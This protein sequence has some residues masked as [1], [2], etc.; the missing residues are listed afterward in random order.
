MVDVRNLV[1]QVAEAV[2]R[3]SEPLT[4]AAA[5][6]AEVGVSMAAQGRQVSVAVTDAVLAALR[7]LPDRLRE[8]EV[9][10]AKHNLEDV[11]DQLGKIAVRLRR[12]SGQLGEASS[13]LGEPALRNSGQLVVNGFVAAASGAR[14]LRPNEQGAVRWLPRAIARPYVDGI[15]TV[16]LG[17]STAGDLARACVNA[18]PGMGA[19]LG[20]IADDLGRAS[21]L[22]EATSK[23]IRD[24]AELVPI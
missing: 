12:L 17:L 18:L 6:T 5:D 23:T 24:L 10:R 16:Y 4:Q 19:G 8:L 21:E 14:F 1:E 13:R 22:L 7:G 2:A 20:E 15:T 11:A 3:A 9:P